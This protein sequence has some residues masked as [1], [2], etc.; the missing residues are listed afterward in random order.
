MVKKGVNQKI[1]VSVVNTSDKDLEISARMIIGDVEMVSTVTP[2][3][4]RLKDNSD[5]V[6]VVDSST[7]K[8]EWEC[9][10][11]ELEVESEEKYLKLKQQLQEI[12]LNHLDKEVQEKVRNML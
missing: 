4:V 2:M 11:V 5:S 12:D 9:N 1:K 7:D 3:A 10:E 6:R 8:T